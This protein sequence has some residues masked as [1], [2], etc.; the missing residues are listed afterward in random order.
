MDASSPQPTPSPT[1]FAPRWEWRTFGTSLVAKERVFA[2]PEAVQESD[3]VYL[4]SEAGTDEAAGT[5]SAKIRDGLIDIKTLREVDARGLEQWT[6]TMKEPFPL[7]ADDV[8]RV[9]AALQIEP[10]SLERARYACG[11]GA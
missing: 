8:R 2:T 11:P 1:A 6:P 4:L 10:P 7:A 5:Q 9:F 3:E